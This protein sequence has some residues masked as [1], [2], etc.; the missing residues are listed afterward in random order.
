MENRKEFLLRKNK[1]RLEFDT[2][3]NALKQ[4]GLNVERSAF[5]TLEESDI[6]F[7]KTKNINNIK[8]S[9]IFNA[10]EEKQGA[11]IYVNKVIEENVSHE[12]TYLWTDYSKYCGLFRID[13]DM[14]NGKSIT[15]IL[16]DK[17][18]GGYCSLLS[19]GVK[20]T[21]DLDEDYDENGGY[22]WLYSVSVLK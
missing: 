14:L 7:D 20:L 15:N 22:N 18:F 10:K 3:L 11:E 12:M 9:K 19:E 6:L 4:A 16:D 8:S 13:G 21:F 1:G 2:Y 5:L 17:Y